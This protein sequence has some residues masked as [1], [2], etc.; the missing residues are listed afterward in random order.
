MITTALQS[1]REELSVANQDPGGLAKRRTELALIKI[2][3]IQVKTNFELLHLRNLPHKTPQ[4]I[5]ERGV[6]T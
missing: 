4:R 6:P 2:N 5:L 3:I 1:Q